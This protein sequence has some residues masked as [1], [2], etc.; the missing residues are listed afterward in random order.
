VFPVV[1]VV[2]HRYEA[3]FI[4]IIIALHVSQE[5]D[6]VQSLVHVVFIIQDNL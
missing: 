4:S 2:V 6:L 3:D 5:L 1:E